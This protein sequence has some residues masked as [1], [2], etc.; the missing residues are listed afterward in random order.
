MTL[1]RQTTPAR[2]ARTTGSLRHGGRTPRRDPYGRAGN[3]GATQR[4]LR[5]ER[6]ATRRYP[7][8]CGV[9]GV[10]DD[11]AHPSVS[12]WVTTLSHPSL[13][14]REVSRRHTASWKACSCTGGAACRASIAWKNPKASASSPASS[15]GSSCLIQPN[16]ASENSQK[17][18]SRA[19]LYQLLHAITKFSVTQMAIVTEWAS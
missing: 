6:H 17:R 8:R 11:D 3:L 2:R 15:S 1:E 16:R 19:F 7:V 18:P 13:S 9:K 14:G 12:F 5:R 10:L 4:R